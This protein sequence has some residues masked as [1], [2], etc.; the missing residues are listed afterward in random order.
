MMMWTYIE[1]IGGEDDDSWKWFLRKKEHGFLS[2]LRMSRSGQKSRL[3]GNTDYPIVFLSQRPSKYIKRPS[4]SRHCSGNGTAQVQK[5]RCNRWLT[6]KE[7][8]VGFM[9]QRYLLKS[10]FLWFGSRG[11]WNVNGYR[12]RTKCIKLVCWD[13]LGY[14]HTKTA[15]RLPQRQPLML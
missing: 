12:K 10:K 4:K 8:A 7:P 1:K 5:W 15:P 13:S 2:D 9:Q 11:Q 6:M 14:W 3:V